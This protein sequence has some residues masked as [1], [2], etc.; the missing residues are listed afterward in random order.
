M[1]TTQKL[2]EISDLK[3]RLKIFT[4]IELRRKTQYDHNIL[5]VKGLTQ[6]SLIFHW[7]IT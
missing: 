2:C 5:R 1:M 4:K 7:L 6:I 3:E